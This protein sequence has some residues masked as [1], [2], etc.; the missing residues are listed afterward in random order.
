MKREQLEQLDPAVPLY[1]CPECLRLRPS[2]SELIVH[3]TS[4]HNFPGW[5]ARKS[6][7]QVQPKLPHEI[8]ARP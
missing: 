5:H 7:D 6:A 2:R 4:R 1:E 3:L 8:E